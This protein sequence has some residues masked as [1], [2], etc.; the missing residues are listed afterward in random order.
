M[1]VSV[2]LT[3]EKNEVILEYNIFMLIDRI[4]Y[5]PDLAFI[6]YQFCKTVN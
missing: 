4:M 6:A 1:F 3:G 5:H 2:D